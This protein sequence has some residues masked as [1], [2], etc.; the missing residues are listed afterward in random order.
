MKKQLKLGAVLLL[1]ASLFHGFAAR[2]QGIMQEE[3]V[4]Y[5]LTLIDAGADG[6]GN[7]KTGG[8]VTEST[9]KVRLKVTVSVP[10]ATGSNYYSAIPTYAAPARL[11]FRKHRGPD[12]AFDGTIPLMRD[13]PYTSSAAT[14]SATTS[15][16]PMPQ[17]DAEGLSITDARQLNLTAVDANSATNRDGTPYMDYIGL[18]RAYD[19]GRWEATYLSTEAFDMNVVLNAPDD[20]EAK[21][22]MVRSLLTGEG[23]YEW[24]VA[25]R[26]G[27]GSV[28]RISDIQ[29]HGRNMTFNDLR[30]WTHQGAESTYLDED[31]RQT[32]GKYENWILASM[33][34]GNASDPLDSWKI[35]KGSIGVNYQGVSGV[36]LLNNSVITTDL[37]ETARVESPVYPDGVSM[38]EFD[39]LTTAQD[40]D[41]DATLLV[42]YSVYDRPWLTLTELTLTAN[43]QRFKINFNDLAPEN[44]QTRFRLVRNAVN[45]TG[46]SANVHTYVIRNLI[47]KSAAPKA[48][49]SKLTVQVNDGVGSAEPHAGAEF[50]VSVRATAESGKAPRGYKGV[51]QLRR[52]AEGDA[53]RVWYDVPASVSYNPNTGDGLLTATFTPGSLLT[54]PDGTLNVKDNAFFTKTEGDVTGVLPGV[55][56]VMVKC[57]VFGSFE[58]GREAI[59]GYEGTEQILDGYDVEETGVNGLPE[60]VHYPYILN[61]RERPAV[62]QSVFMRVMYRTGNSTDNYDLDTFDVPLLPSGKTADVWRIDLAKLLKLAESTAVYAW[63]YES[64]NPDDA[65]VY[66]TGYIAFKLCAVAADGSETWYGLNSAISSAATRPA[67]VEVVPSVAETLATATSE[68]TAVPILVAVDSLPNSHLMV[69]LNL[70]DPQAA[71]ANMAGSFWQDF[72]MWDPS[73]TFVETE[74]RENVTA[75]VADFDCESSTQD[76]ETKLIAGWIPDEGPLADTTAFLDEVAVGRLSQRGQYPFILRDKSY[77]SDTRLFASWGA[78]PDRAE[79][80]YLRVDDSDSIYSDYLQFNSQTEVVLRRGIYSPT[81]NIYGTDAL[82]RLCGAGA[83]SPRHDTG[84]SITLNGVGKVSFNLSLSLPYDIN[85]IAQFVSTDENN[86]MNYKGTGLS[87]SVS[88]TNPSQTCAPSGYSV[89]YYLI[90]YANPLSPVLYELRVSQVMEFPTTESE[91]PLERVVMELYKWNGGSATRLTLTVSGN[92]GVDESFHYA[93]SDLDGSTYGLWVMADGRIAIG[94]AAGT[95]SSALNT[96]AFSKDVLISNPTT[97]QLNFALGSAECRPIFRQIDRVTTVGS[98][99]NGSPVSPDA[100]TVMTPS[101]SGGRSVWRVS[102]DSGKTARIQIARITPTASQVGRVKVTARSATGTKTYD[103]ATDKMDQLC[104]LTVGAAN[105]EL[106]IEPYDENCNIFVDNIAISSWCGNDENRNGRDRV[107][108]F[109]DEGFAA[110]T[111]FM[112]VGVWIRPEDDAQLN[113]L[114]SNYSGRQCLLL[115]RSRQN[116]TYD[117]KETTTNGVTH[118]GNSLALY[119]PFSDKGYGPISFRYRIPQYDEYGNQGELPSVRVM[120]QYTDDGPYQSFLGKNIPGESEWKNASDP[121]ELRNTSG[122]WSMVSITPKVNGTELVDTEGTLRLVMVISGDMEASDDPYVYIDDVRVTTNEGGSTASWSATNVRVSETPVSTLYWKDRLPTE[123]ASPEEVTF[124]QKSTLTRAMQ[125]NNVMTDEETEGTYATTVIESPI[126]DNGVGRVVFAARLAEPQTKPVRLYIC[127]TTDATDAKVGLQPVTYVDVANTV[128]TIYDIDLSKYRNYYTVPN[129]DGSPSTTATGDAFSCSAIRRVTLKAFIEGDGVQ[130]DGFGATPV[131]GRVLIDQLAIA[132]PVLP[133][134]RVASVAFSNL[135]G[136]LSANEFDAR[137]PLSQPVQNA[138]ILRTMVR[139]DRAQLLKNDSIRVFL[140]VN[141]QPVNAA[142]AL[143]QYVN[144]YSYTDVL[145]GTVS[146]SEQHPIYSWD[147]DNLEAWPLSAWFNSSDMFAK[148]ATKLDNPTVLSVDDLMAINIDNTIE[149]TRD[150]TDSLCYYGDLSALS[151]FNNILSLPENS[152]VRYNA[153]AVYQSEDSDQWFFTQISPSNYTEFPW[154]FPRSLNAELREKASTE[155]DKKTASFFSPYYW[156]YSYLPGE[157]FINEFNFNDNSG[158]IANSTRHFV[159]ICAPVNTNLGGWRVEMTTSNSPSEISESSISIAPDAPTATAETNKTLPEPDLGAVPYQRKDATSAQRSFYTAFS[160]DSRVYYREEGETK[161]DLAKTK[162]AGIAD[163]SIEYWYSLGSGTQASSVRLHRP[164]GGAEHIVCFSLNGEGNVANTQSQNNLTRL[165]DSYRVAYSEK[166]FGGEWEQT[167]TTGTWE[168]YSKTSAPDTFGADPAVITA[169]MHARRLVKADTFIADTANANRFALNATGSA[170]INDVANT[171]FANSIATVDMGGVF[172]TRKNAINADVEN[173]PLDLTDV[174]VGTW[175]VAVNPTIQTRITEPTGGEADLDPVVQVTPRQINPDQYL[176]LYSGFSSSVVTSELTGRLGSH[177][178]DTLDKNRTS[179]QV[180]VAGRETPYTWGLSLDVAYTALTYTALPFHTVESV[181]FRLKDASDPSKFITDVAKL[182]QL[183]TVTGGTVDVNAAAANEGWMTVTIPAGT[184]AVTVT[185]ASAD[186]DDDEV[187]YSVE[188]KGS[189]ALDPSGGAARD[190]ITQVR[191]YCGEGSADFPVPGSAKYQ[192]WWGSNFGFEVAYDD[193]GLAD[194][195]VLSSLIVTY[196]SPSALANSAWDGI[197]SPWTGWSHDITVADP[198]DPTL[199]TTVTT[200]LEGMEY[201]DALELLK[202]Q[203]V[204]NAGT[205]YVEMPG[206]ADGFFTDASLISTLGDTYA[207]AVGYDGTA[208]TAAKKEPAIPFCVWG[209]YTVTLPT[210]RGNEKVSFLMR[211]AMPGEKA[212]VWTQPAHYAPLADLNNGKTAEET[213]PYFYLYS[214]PPQA[215][216]VNEVNLVKGSAADV[217]PFV[218][219]VFP[220]LREG[221]LSATAPVVAQADPAGWEVRRYVENTQTSVIG[222]LNAATVTTSG[223]TSYNY[224]TLAMAEDTATRAAYVLH[225]PCGAAEGGL[226]TGVDADG[227][228][229]I[230][231]PDANALGAEAWL[232]PPETSFVVPG[233]SDATAQP[234][235]V[236]LIGQVVYRDGY[237]RLSSA[238]AERTD[239]TFAPATQGSDNEG[240]MRPDTKPV[241]NQVTITS[242]IRNTVYAGT[243]SGYQLVPGVFSQENLLGETDPITVTQSGRDWVYNDALDGLVISYR[244]RANYRFESMTLPAELIGKVMLIGRR[245]ALTP[246]NILERVTELKREAVLEPAVTTTSWVNLNGRAK[247][248]MRTVVDAAGAH[249]EPT[250][251]I[252]FDTEFYEGDDDEGEAITFG[253]L[254]D[255]VISLVI[256]SEPSSAQNA[257][258]VAFGQGEVKAGAWMVSQTLYALD[259]NGAPDA[260]RGGDAVTLPIWSDETGN[261]NG[262][263]ANL[264]GWLYQ[265]VSGDTIGMTAVINP[266]LGLQGGK[267]S[268]PTVSMSSANASLRPFLVWTAIPKS[269]VPTNLFDA[270]APNTAIEMTRNDFIKGWGLNAWLGSPSVQDGVT[271]QLTSLRRKLRSGA[272]STASTALYAKAGIIPMIYQGYCDK[273]GDVS[274]LDDDDNRAAETLLSFRTMSADELAAAIQNAAFTG[275]TTDGTLDTDANPLLPYTS[276]IDMTDASFWQD[277]AILRFAVVIADAVTGY[278]YDCQS[279]SNFSSEALEAYCPWYIPDETTNI[280]RATSSA[281]AG[282]GVSPFA[283]IYNIPQG[284]VWI[285]EFRPFAIANA[286]AGRVASAF[287]LAMKASPLAE[288][289]P[290]KGIFKPTRSLDGWKVITRY[291]PMPA[292]GSDPA[293]PIRWQKHKEVALYSWVPY[294]RIVK[295]Q[296]DISGNPDLYTNADFTLDFYTATVDAVRD[297]TVDLDATLSNM[298]DYY[299]EAVYK[300]P[301]GTVNPDTFQWLNFNLKNE[302]TKSDYDLFDADLQATLTAKDDGIYADG[303]IYSIALVR[304]NGAIEDEVLFY[305]ASPYAGIT[306]GDDYL[307]ARMDIAVESETTNKACAGVVRAVTSTPLPSTNTNVRQCTVQFLNFTNA[308]G[309]SSLNWYV[310]PTKNGIYS[311][312]SSPNTMTSGG[313]TF[314]QPYVEYATTG[315]TFERLEAGITGGDGATLELTNNGNTVTGRSVVT[316]A[317]VGSAYELTLKDWN[318]DWYKLAVKRNNADFTP[319]ESYALATTYALNGSAQTYATTKNLV[320]DRDTVATSVVYNLVFTYTDDAAL[321]ATAGALDS[322]DPGFATW[323]QQATPAEIATQS[324][325]DGTTAAEKYWL[326]AATPNEATDPALAFTDIAMF[327]DLN[328]TAERPKVSVKLTNNGVRI[329][330]L[331]GD[332]NVVLLGKKALSDTEWTY[333]K[334]LGEADLADGAEIILATDCKF[335]RA[336]LMSDAAIQALIAP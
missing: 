328:A 330:A 19:V 119:L 118:T 198:N 52:R 228:A 26:R 23:T 107:P 208:A 128:Y 36:Q 336:V 184:T 214:T 219:V 87:A 94:S 174:M 222:T 223:S 290:V 320:I 261:K 299:K 206:G 191:P 92:N 114:P 210:S 60:T 61:V 42:Q 85:T 178:L 207:K 192:P 308:Q 229:T 187:R 65:L 200:G 78:S 183:I 277:G 152:L 14:A 313:I 116:N 102:A 232:V 319:V 307:L 75:V 33:P 82:F 17:A 221:I 289:D 122:E 238:V 193:S 189:F 39:A 135:P 59:D 134:V 234:G 164:T 131:Y 216:W 115:Q 316:Y 73:E 258:E 117:Y 79:P 34:L 314:T 248:E 297:P 269:R 285:N 172:V 301:D 201:A 251:K 310:A 305:A 257:I 244:P 81:G 227:N 283:W 143:K 103:F 70:A 160:P 323:L 303:V 204:P 156:V 72:N 288:E 64:G 247:L 217:D 271:L 1:S 245:G 121:I 15:Y 293:T 62:A 237:P 312:L 24:F 273:N 68:A 46:G 159:E 100:V 148:I 311:T 215:A 90:D 262:E 162:N 140:T 242:T 230:V 27:L 252:L 157:A 2:A 5:A 120:L 155:T 150:P 3:R 105:A 44:A 249:T 67:P 199:T 203:L 151:R 169:Q 250:G 18:G 266:D 278:V 6:S 40:A 7:T 31:S 12:T 77:I 126:L 29:D 38:V 265:P 212:G 194:G 317:Q 166:G 267:L 246:E 302:D 284:G 124:A 88:F 83:L 112:G 9:Q 149:L 263:N 243:S 80:E 133:S 16:Y 125:F 321:L 236:Q 254:D 54:N 329:T 109:T 296:A 144:T 255:Y 104:E 276:S 260:E 138:S 96:L 298:T 55:Y 25:S 171:T 110:N 97:K 141:P 233:K 324:A 274:T 63:G 213:I 333:L 20:A 168:D 123:G 287:E 146:A 56:D 145:G 225:R 334:T 163:R 331:N 335:F 279:I 181:T 76:G 182:T 22:L 202:T 211:Q 101:Y 35:Y 158:A 259:A 270:S 53:S 280:N 84:A 58:A 188:A 43:L 179:L 306:D 176:V 86:L 209:V 226:W 264:H 175:P 74:F 239:W 281:E 21:I 241:W 51:I 154:Y 57:S 93:G 95:A 325:T 332:G 304:N 224:L 326:G 71:V 99:Y 256:V 196:P 220:V 69:E 197:A 30:L 253:D 153:W 28:A 295:A 300:N 180:S 195:T 185:T 41:Q 294:R 318:T 231:P 170:Y 8:P 13:A 47:V 98:N 142:S 66:E 235:S 11:M 165:Y 167:F 327:A 136:T 173:G 286:D 275:L 218:E 10:R 129:A 186:P 108:L 89:S 45:V 147:Q 315:T 113:A 106:T 130:T 48:S 111:G 127:A 161:T 268:D 50:S 309:T 49:F 282:G 137:S 177:T 132:N 37:S 292:L 91:K 291:A 190:V 272:E 322:E 139:L 205:R 32:L 240:E 4:S